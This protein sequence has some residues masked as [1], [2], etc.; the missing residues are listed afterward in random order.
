MRQ[1][2]VGF[3]ALL[4]ACSEYQLE[5]EPEPEEVDSGTPPDPIPDPEDTGVPIEDPPDTDVDPSRPIALCNVSPNPVRPPFESAVWNDAGSNDPEGEA[6]VGF[7]WTLVSQPSGSSVVM[8]PGSGPA[9]DFMPDMAGDYVG[10][11]IVTTTDGRTSEPCT[12]TLEAIPAEN[13]WVEMFWAHSG[14]DMDL[15]LL[16]PGGAMEQGNHDCYYANC[17]TGQGL[18]WGVPGDPI[19]NARLDLDDIPGTGPENINIGDPVPGVYTVVVNDYPGSVY[20]GDN[21]VTVNIYIDGV[22][23]WTDTRTISGEDDDVPFAEIDWST[24]IV[25]GL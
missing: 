20:N 2:S 5:P 6:I 4:A 16:D 18:D 23:Q 13:L 1:L 21:D 10:E 7:T 14:D 8:P 19:D 17:T 15:H 11:L 24:G 25:T 9:R 12:T 3:F 22:V